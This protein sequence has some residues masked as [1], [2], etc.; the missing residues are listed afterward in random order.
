M[1]TQ[2]YRDIN[3]R[4]WSFFSSAGCDS[5]KPFGPTEFARARYWLDSYGWLPWNQVKSVLCIACGGG[6][7]A[8]LFASLGCQVTSLDLCREQL[9]KDR[10]A[11]TRHGLEIECVEGDMLDLSLLYGRSYDLV[12]QA[13]SACYVPDVRRLYREVHKVLRADGYYR[14][15]HWNPVHF[16]LADP[17]W[18]GGAYRVDRPQTYKEPLPW[19][20]LQ[21]ENTGGIP[22]CHH[23]IHPL[24]DLI[25]S[26]CDENFQII[27]FAET[28]ETNPNAAPCTFPHLSA[29]LP[30]FFL[31]LARRGLSRSR[32]PSEP[33]SAS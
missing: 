7:Q 14:V 31:L 27:R 23:Y 22:S 11:A 21:K 8:A 17:P 18:D 15:E 16:Q 20:G 1:T 3:R 5:A 25:G 28:G 9:E 24:Q 26:M 4:A 13:V 32:T 12:Y 30:T 6:Q 29:F 33:S 2:D 19:L 10:N